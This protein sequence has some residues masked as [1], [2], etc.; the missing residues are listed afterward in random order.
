MLDQL[1]S[2]QLSFGRSTGI[3]QEFERE[4]ATYHGVPYCISTHCGTG[5]LHAAF[6]ALGLAPGDEVLAP[7]Y[8]HLAS[9]M[10]MLHANLIPVLCDVDEE[11]GNLDVED[12]ERRKTARTRAIVV[13]HEYGNVCD[14]DRVNELARKHNLLVVEDAS[15]AHGATYKGRLAGALG[16]VACFSLQSH[17]IITAG[18]GGALITRHSRIAE[19]AALLAHFR[20]KPAWASDTYAPFFET[21]YGLKNRLHPLGAALVLTQLRK[22]PQLIAQR[23]ANWTFF[24]ERLRNIKGVRALPLQPGVTRGGYFRFV[25]KCVPEELDHLPIETYIRALRA[26]GVAEVMPGSMAKPLH[27]T[28]LFQTVHD[29]MY[30]DGWPRRGAHVSQERVYK[31]GDFPRAERFSAMTL[32]FPAFTE[33][34]DH[35][36]EAYCQAMEKVAEQVGS[37]LAQSA[38]AAG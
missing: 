24:E 13:T 10:P 12:A 8:T 5:A 17:K 32:Q 23:D 33:P 37:L 25:L 16:D 3:I 19:R 2:G 28:P 38:A 11:T 29:N 14:M 30:P 4:F 9:V 18:E 26:E 22:L 27:L 6:F 1:R 7:A 35:I 15:H 21:G 36:I 20:E 31:P 34:S